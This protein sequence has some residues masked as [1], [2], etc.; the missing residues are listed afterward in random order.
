MSELY[1][2]AGVDLEAGYEAVER[3]KKHVERTK[4][5]GCH[6]LFG[7]FGGMFDLS[8]YGYQQPVLVSGTDGVGTKLLFAIHHDRH[9]TI[10]QDLVAMCVNDIIAQGAKPLFFLD[11]IACD[12]NRPAQIE[13]IVAGI[14]DGCELS[15]C[16]L[17]GGETAEM[18]NMYSEGHYDLAGFVVGAVEKTKLVT[19]KTVKPGQVI[20]GLT[21]SGIHSNGYS[22]VHKL[23]ADNGVDVTQS[24]S[25]LG[26]SPLDALLQPTKIYVQ[27][28]LKVM[29]QVTVHGAAHITGGGFYE[30]VPRTLNGFGATFQHGQWP[31]P[32]IFDYLQQLGDISHEEMYNVFN[33]G[34][35]F[36]LIVDGIDVAQTLEILSD[37][38]QPAFVIGE[39]TQVPQV[40]IES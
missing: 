11:Y 40:V 14:A 28:V 3:I 24:Q 13:Q 31:R 9:E 25:I 37:A 7:A 36:M 32:A 38:N 33:M 10:G 27:P 34:I 1:K 20:I 5:K 35:G 15:D 17:I 6:D 21:S 2:A 8:Q 4:T 16:A 18:P 12:H 39:V 22:L 23:L 26:Q 29:E 30:N 19:G